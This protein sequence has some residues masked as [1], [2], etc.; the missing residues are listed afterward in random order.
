MSCMQ[1]LEEPNRQKRE[2]R[3]GTRQIGVEFVEGGVAKDWL[4]GRYILLIS[5][6]F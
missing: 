4:C 1:D 6:T 5:S 3:T 2:D